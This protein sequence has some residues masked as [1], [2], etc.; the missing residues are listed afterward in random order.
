MNITARA[1][2]AAKTGCNFVVAQ[3]DVRAARWTISRYGRFADVVLALALK[4]LNR[5]A[6]RLTPSAGKLL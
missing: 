3:V 4:A 6:A 5:Q 2:T 1:D